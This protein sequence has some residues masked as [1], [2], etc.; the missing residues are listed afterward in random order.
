MSVVAVIGWWFTGGFFS[1]LIGVMLVSSLKCK[2]CGLEIPAVGQWRVGSYTDHRE[3]HILA[4]KNP[5]DG[6]RVGHFDCP[7]CSATI[8]V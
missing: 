2:S 7:Q 8:L 4:A 1:R 3:R 6:G 5:I